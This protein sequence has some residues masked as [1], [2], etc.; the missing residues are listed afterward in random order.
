MR[1]PHFTEYG[2]MGRESDEHPGGKP[3]SPRFV[4]YPETNQ[5]PVR[6]V[7]PSRFATTRS[8]GERPSTDGTK[9]RYG[10]S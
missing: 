7:S 5:S 8:S 2:W 9:R 1:M 10:D 3:A 6:W 4:V